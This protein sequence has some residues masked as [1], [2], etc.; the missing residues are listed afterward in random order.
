MSGR[1]LKKTIIAETAAYAVTGCIV[2]GVLGLLLH[3]LLYGLIIT[4]N[5]GEIWQPPIAVLAV[6]MVAVLLTTFVSV[7]SV[8]GKIKEMSIV[9]VVNA[10]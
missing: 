7:H 1:Q 9:N 2:G 10:G 5:W 8:A 4:S 6:T 3:R